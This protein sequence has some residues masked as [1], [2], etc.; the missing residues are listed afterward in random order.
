MDLQAVQR[1]ILTL[2][3]K[4][5][6]KHRFI[7]KFHWTIQQILKPFLIFYISFVEDQ[8]D[9]LVKL[10][11]IQRQKY[12]KDVV[13][14]KSLDAR[15]KLKGRRLR[16]EEYA[17]YLNE[18]KGPG[19]PF[20]T[21][22]QFPFTGFLIPASLIITTVDPKKDRVKLQL[23]KLVTFED[24]PKPPS[25]TPNLLLC[26][27]QLESFTSSLQKEIQLVHCIETLFENELNHL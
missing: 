20:L 17:L 25:L 22:N 11:A 13:S 5:L 12:K 23:S 18:Y 15:R 26:Q 7:Q 4:I 24:P 9:E 19:S 2:I 14:L 16:V 8:F 27:A 21:S 3:E 6:Q 10:Y 1:E